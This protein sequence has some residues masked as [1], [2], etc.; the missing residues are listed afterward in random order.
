MYAFCSTHGHKPQQSNFAT[1]TISVRIPPH[2]HMSQ[3]TVSDFEGG[4]RPQLYPRVEKAKSKRG[5]APY[6]I[7]SPNIKLA[8]VRLLYRFLIHVAA[9]I[10]VLT[11]LLAFG[12][13]LSTNPT[14][15]LL[16]IC[17]MQNTVCS[18]SS[19]LWQSY[20][21]IA[22]CEALSPSPS[23]SQLRPDYA[24]ASNGGRIVP[25]LSSPTNGYTRMSLSE[26][27]LYE[28]RGYSH[29]HLDIVPPT[30]VIASYV[31][32]GVCWSFEG[33]QGHL[34]VSLRR[35]INVTHVTFHHPPVEELLE[36]QLQ[37]TPTFLTLWFLV[38]AANDI[39]DVNRTTTSV[40]R[41]AKPSWNALEFSSSILVMAASL[42]YY[43]EKGTRQTFTL[44]APVVSSV[45]V[46]EVHENGGGRQTCLYRISVHGTDI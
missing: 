28:V 7:P 17:D 36:E 26:W 39:G 34:G 40:E 43:P 27:L 23:I 12:R 21:P 8:A 16:T 13:R 5:Q 31:H 24:L 14:F 18:L 29:K 37:Q 15:S 33:S 3:S 35:L 20:C 44:P 19:T 30:A 2:H 42:H 22:T 45:M 4:N 41:F 9:T 46:L 25:H 6:K 32:A 11:T 38:P 1:V 10:A